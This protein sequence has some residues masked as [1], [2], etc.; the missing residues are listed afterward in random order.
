MVGIYFQAVIQQPFDVIFQS[1][2][3]DQTGRSRPEAALVWNSAWV[4]CHQQIQ[5][6]RRKTDLTAFKFSLN[7][8]TNLCFLNPNYK[9]ELTLNPACPAQPEGWRREPIYPSKLYGYP[10]SACEHAAYRVWALKFRQPHPC[11]WLSNW[12]APALG[13]YGRIQ[14]LPMFWGMSANPVAAG[15]IH[16]PVAA[17][18]PIILRWSMNS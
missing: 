11:S 15:S 12:C 18:G 16:P 10:V 17:W 5:L 14:G 7:R 8:I 6:P 4:L 13:Q 3:S 1:F 2:Y 9:I